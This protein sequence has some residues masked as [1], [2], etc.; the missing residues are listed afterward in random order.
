[1]SEISY[2][3]LVWLSYRLGATF[4]FGIPLVLFIWSTIKKE[5]SIIRLLSIYWKVASLMLV[6]MLLL[7]G[8]RSIGYLTSFLSPFLMIICVWFWI[9]LNEELREFPP[10]KA[11]PFVLKAWRWA[12]SGYGCFYASLSFKSLNCLNQ[13]ESYQCPLWREAPS[14]LNQVIKNTFNFLFGASWTEV[15]SAFV[16]YLGLII[17]IVGLVQWL[18]IRFP[19]KGRIAGDF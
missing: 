4:A 18:I 16:G 2:R 14:G 11:L 6:S 8:N 1:M 5:P 9:D 7:T 19:K 15:L 12:L 17:Y 13:I 10:K 3:S